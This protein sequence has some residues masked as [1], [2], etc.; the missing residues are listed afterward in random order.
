L[1]KRI[2][3]GLNDNN[4]VE[5]L[6][7][8]TAND[9]VATGIISGPAASAASAAATGSPFLPKRVPGGGKSR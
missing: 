6:S 5:V 3:I 8:L 7:G 2:E 9:L 4:Q 1:Q